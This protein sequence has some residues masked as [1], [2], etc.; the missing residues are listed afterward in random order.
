MDSENV[1]DTN[2]ED[3]MNV[4]HNSEFQVH[5]ITTT[6]LY[7]HELIQILTHVRKELEKRQNM[8]VAS[9]LWVIVHALYFLELLSQYRPRQINDNNFEREI[10]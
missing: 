7:H 2:F 9:L 5:Q 3:T 6:D 4:I 8:C 1:E 10:S